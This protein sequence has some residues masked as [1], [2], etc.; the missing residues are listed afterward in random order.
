V[1]AAETGIEIV[2][3]LHHPNPNQVG[4][5]AI[6]IVANDHIHPHRLRHPR[7]PRRRRRHIRETITRIR[8]RRPIRGMTLVAEAGVE[9]AATVDPIPVPMTT[10]NAENETR[11]LLAPRLRPGMCLVETRSTVEEEARGMTDD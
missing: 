7:P 4:G 9:V 11:P 8:T 5:T 1:I 10:T 3:R 6:V 2:T